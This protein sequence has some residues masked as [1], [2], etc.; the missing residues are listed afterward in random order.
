MAGTTNQEHDVARVSHLMKIKT[1]SLLLF[2]FLIDPNN[3]TFYI[4]L[5]P[6]SL[7]LFIPFNTIVVPRL[8]FKRDDCHISVSAA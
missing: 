6:F 4:F 8:A 2:S 5:C 1:I 3:G 7:F